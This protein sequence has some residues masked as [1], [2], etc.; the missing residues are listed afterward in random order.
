[1]LIQVML[2]FLGLA[3]LFIVLGQR[4]DNL[5][6]QISGFLIICLLSFTFFSGVL[7]FKTGENLTT[8][9]TYTDGNLTSNHQSMIYTYSEPAGITN[10]VYYGLMMLFSGLVGLFGVW[11]NYKADFRGSYDDED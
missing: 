10:K 9:Y 4:V 11:N 1:M 3:S 8:S 2:I 5:V 6:M 7:E